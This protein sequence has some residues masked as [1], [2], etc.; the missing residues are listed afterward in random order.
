MKETE[1]FALELTEGEL[2]WLLQALGKLNVVLPRGSFYSL[3]SATLHEHLER[4]RMELVQRGLIRPRAGIGMEID[5]FIVSL[6]EWISAPEKI[7]LIQVLRS[8]TESC[9]AGL[10]S[11]A[12]KS[13]LFE[14]LNDCYRLIL[15]RKDEDL[16]AYIRDLFG[17]PLTINPNLGRV[18]RLPEPISLLRLFWRDPQAVQYALR[19]CGMTLDESSTALDC[20]R[21]W[22]TLTQLNFLQA[23]E[24]E[25]CSVG[26]CFL[27]SDG[28]HLWATSIHKMETRDFVFV[29]LLEDLKLDFI[30]RGIGSTAEES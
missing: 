27:A 11:R 19:V 24:K 22:K 7:A 16:W 12:R 18:F 3:T 26:T 6:V 9:T 1:R 30:V 5:R 23:E 29:P 20:L 21:E 15:F 14:S 17:I 2:L 10:Y 13:L 25:L 4:G 28:T 8:P